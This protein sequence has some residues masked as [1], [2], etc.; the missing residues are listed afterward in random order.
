M[1]VFDWLLLRDHLNTKNLMIRKHWTFDGGPDCVLCIGHVHEDSDHLFFRCQFAT[2]CWLLVGISWDCNLELSQRIV[3][4]KS[5]FT[6]PCFM[7]IFSCAAWNIWK[8]RN[9]FI[10]NNIRPSLSRWKVR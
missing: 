4:A 5:V 1:R 3:K 8:E 6:G 7:E 10:F 2:I 9:E